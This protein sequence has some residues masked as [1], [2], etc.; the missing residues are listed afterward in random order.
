MISEM[1]PK[2]AKPAFFVLAPWG[3][4]PFSSTKILAEGKRSRNARAACKP[5]MPLPTMVKSMLVNQFFI[6]Q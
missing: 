5:T 2:Q 4:T 6:S 1:L 3:K